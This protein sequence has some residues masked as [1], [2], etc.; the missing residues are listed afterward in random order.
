MG[1]GTKG[2]KSRKKFCF[3]R[4]ML[5]ISIFEKKEREIKEKTY[6]VH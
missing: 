6:T 1:E 4:G 3:A 5:Y 2:Q